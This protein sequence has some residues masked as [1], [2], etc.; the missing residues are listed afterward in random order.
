MPNWL[1]S[2]DHSIS[3]VTPGGTPNAAIADLFTINVTTATGF[4]IPNT[5]TPSIGHEYV[6]DVKNTSGAAMG[7]ITWG[8]TYRMAGAWTNP[9]TGNHRLI[10]FW[11][12]GTDMI[13]ITRSPSDVA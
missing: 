8:S 10:R 2:P 1:N 7:L 5:T 12:D 4:T 9:S 6:F 3:A 11:W 13:E